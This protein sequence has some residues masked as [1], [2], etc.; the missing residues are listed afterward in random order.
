M[1]RVASS[2]VLDEV[3]KAV[4]WFLRYTQ[5]RFITQYDYRVCLTV[6]LYCKTGLYAIYTT[7]YTVKQWNG[8]FHMTT[9][10]LWSPV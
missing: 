6:Y 10:I 9:K 7:M 3:E 2:V 8:P 5:N 4:R 1:S